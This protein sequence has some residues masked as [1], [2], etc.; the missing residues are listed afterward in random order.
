MNMFKVTNEVRGILIKSKEIAGYVEDKIFPVMAPENT[1]GDYIIY[2][3]DGYKQEYSK[4]GV[5][6]QTPLVNV[7][8][9]IFHGATRFSSIK[10]AIRC[11]RT[12]V[13]PEPAPART[14]S[15]PS[16]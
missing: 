14:R 6:R 2:Q 9:M 1:D 13:F 10:Y 4:M 12:R 7:I 16:V 8:A 5:A 15:G 3:R 11:V